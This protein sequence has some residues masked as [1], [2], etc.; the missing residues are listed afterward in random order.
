MTSGGPLAGIKVVELAGIGPGPH[1]ATLLADLG[2]DVVRVQRAGALPGEGATGDPLIRNRRIVEA[3]LKDPADLDRVQRLVDRADVL[4]EGFRPGVTERMGL[5]PED[6]TGRNPRLIYG[7]MTGWGQDGPWAQTAGHDINYISVTGVLHAIG[8]EGER[9]VPPMNMVGD[10]GGGS[11][12]LVTGILAA[13]VERASSGRGQVI[14]AAMVDGTVALS[15]MIWGWRGIGMWSDER[16]ANLLDTGAPFYDTYETADGKHVAVG[17]LEPQF[18]AALLQGLG[19]DPTALPHQL[20]RAR[21]PELRATFTDVFASRTRDDWAATFDGTDACVT[22]V[23]TFG[24][25]SS[26]PQMAAREN[27]VDVDG[28]TQHAP[29]PRFSRTV[30]TQPEGPARTAADPDEIWT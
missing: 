1:A 20:D 7:R 25:A 14:D 30:P 5:G 27:L 26:H 15:H 18:Y 12:F 19:L 13:L 29:A 16:G 9:P 28:I 8:R 23:L 3:N 2:A 4:I 10:F 11:M 22:P 21:W 17:A 24:E 6:T